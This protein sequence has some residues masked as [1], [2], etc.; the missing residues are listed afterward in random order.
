MRGWLE[1]NFYLLSIDKIND[2]ET[3]EMDFYESKLAFVID[4]FISV[5]G[6]E[7]PQ[8]INQLKNKDPN[9]EKGFHE[10]FDYWKQKGILQ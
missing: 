10:I 8:S 9:N 4:D 7:K 3:I 6:D 1:S 2:K 5:F